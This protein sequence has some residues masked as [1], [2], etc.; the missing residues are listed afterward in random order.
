MSEDAGL[1]RLL[2]LEEMA[3]PDPEE[4]GWCEQ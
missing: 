2:R 1:I 3:G 4:V